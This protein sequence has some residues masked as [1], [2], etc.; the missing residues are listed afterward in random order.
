M[1][2]HAQDPRAS[3]AG[4]R[5]LAMALVERLAAFAR[6]PYDPRGASEAFEAG[7]RELEGPLER[8]WPRRLER[9]GARL[10]LGMRQALLSVDEATAALRRGQSAVTYRPTPANPDGWVLLVDR[11]GNKVF[12]AS[13]DGAS[14]DRWVEIDTLEKELGSP[15]DERLTWLFSDPVL[16]SSADSDHHEHSVPPFERLRQLVRPDRADLWSII[17][18]GLLVGGLTLTTPIAVQQLVNSV[19]LGG[20]LQPVVVLALL[21]L[22]A[23][24]FSAVLS[25]LQAYVAEIVQRRLFVRVV[26]DLAVRLPKVS[27]DAF[28]RRHGPELVNRFF[29]VMT[30]QKTGTSIMLDGVALFLQTTIGL[31]VLSFY[32]P[33]MLA[34]S[35]LLV[36]GINVVV[37][38]FGRGAVVSAVAESRTKYDVAS[39]LEEMA[40]HVATL[41]PHAAAEFALERADLL[42]R[43]YL[44][45]RSTH[46]RIVLRQLLGALG[47]QVIASAALLGLGGAL[48]IAGQLTL[49]QLVA[50]ELIVTAIVASFAKLGKHLEGFYD[51]LAA[52]D[53][54]GHLFDLPVEPDNGSIQERVEGP[55]TLAFHDVAFGY[56]GET[57]IS[58]LDFRI[59]AGERVALVGPTGSGKSVV[60]DLAL[61]LRAPSSGY[62]TVDEQDLRQTHLPSLREQVVC[63]RGPEVIE[64]TIEENVRLGRSY[65][66]AEAVHHAL[67]TVGLLEPLLLRPEGLK[68]RLSSNGAP[69]SRGQAVRLCLARAIAGDPRLILIDEASVNL[70]EHSEDIDLETLFASDSRWSLLIVTTSSRIAGRC[71]RII[72]LPERPSKA[73]GSRPASQSSANEDPR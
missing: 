50:S 2:E 30:V 16:P 58:G 12:R 23:L 4:N 1:P 44:H 8:N 18:F 43:E 13:I 45:A 62:V 67:A 66:S 35:V 26:A 34:F 56:E 22:A 52:V 72:E 31:L 24:S 61:G 33:L 14:G 11:R 60:L 53:K 48:V 68:T 7:E 41:K 65:I 19:A 49:G 28:D 5:A 29:D 54:L 38:V 27:I 63:V 59:D 21:L 6:T 70:D 10:A 20:L 46:Y 3:R 47:L 37:F 40:R 39:W 64:G 25:A 73:T 51:L 71:D 32:H 69:L 17:I 9:M 55:A 57:V 15:G 36:A 42:A